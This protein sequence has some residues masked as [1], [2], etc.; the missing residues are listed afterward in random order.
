MDRIWQWA[1]D[2]YGARWTR[3][4]L[5]LYA[6]CLP[7]TLSV[8]LL[9]TLSIATFEKSGRYLEAAGVT[10]GAALVLVYLMVSSRE[11]GKCG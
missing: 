5:A 10:A 9:L 6:F 8:Y 1:W 11:P 3:Y 2:R 4:R 7:V